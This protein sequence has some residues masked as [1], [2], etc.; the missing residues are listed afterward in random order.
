M[1]FP[2]APTSRKIWHPH[3]LL[4]T[5]WSLLSCRSAVQ[6]SLISHI[7]NKV[8]GEMKMITVA[9]IVFSQ[10][11]L[12]S[13]PNTGCLLFWT[14]EFIPSGVRVGEQTW[15]ILNLNKFAF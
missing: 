6:T 8:V 1:Q 3:I 14:K 7:V 11:Q 5:L 10:L 12:G 13:I 4:L 9:M 15:I 2:W